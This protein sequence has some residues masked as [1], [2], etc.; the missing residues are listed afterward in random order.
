MASEVVESTSIPAAEATQAAAADTQF[1][2][3]VASTKIAKYDRA[4]GQKLAE[5]SGPAKH[6]N[7]AFLMEGR[8]YCAHSNFPQ[9]PEQSEIRVLDTATMAL[10][11]FKDF[12]NYRGSLTWAV[13]EKDAWWCTFAL[14]GADNAGTTLVKFDEQW[15]ELGA[16]T[17]P[18]E[19]IRDLGKFSISG[20]VWKDG[21]L[22]ATG[23]DHKLIYR[24]MLPENGNVLELLQVIPS[25]F[26][27]QGIALDPKTGGF[28][29]INRA[30]K[31]V[32]FGTLRD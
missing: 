7:S 30:K 31:S 18:P 14:Y 32:V 9:K 2:Y 29:G 6:L 26:P 28:V 15:K 1:I 19:V 23:H 22:Y 24:L 12:G 27:G 4:T 17:Y 20:G 11:V 13:Q 25:P 21:Q 10:T 5:S 16:W 8:L 3:A